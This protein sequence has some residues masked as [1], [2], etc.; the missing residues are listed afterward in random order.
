MDCSILA[1]VLFLYFNVI[2]FDFVLIH[3]KKRERIYL[4]NIKSDLDLSLG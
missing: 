3:K 4:D 2:D 1:Q